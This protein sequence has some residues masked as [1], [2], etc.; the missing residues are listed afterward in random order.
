M[1]LPWF[2]YHC[3][4]G[5]EREGIMD[6]AQCSYCIRVNRREMPYKDGEHTLTNKQSRALAALRLLRKNSDNY[7]LGYEVANQAEIDNQAAGAVLAA[8]VRRGLVERRS[9][10][11]HV[12]GHVRYEYRGIPERETRRNW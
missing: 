11:D 6:D 3:D 12:E 2:G 9:A 8:L 7:W 5:I 10:D 4:C 1:T